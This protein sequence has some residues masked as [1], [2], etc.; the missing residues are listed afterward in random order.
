M[1]CIT[2]KSLD[3]CEGTVGEGSERKKVELEKILREYTNNHEQNVCIGMD[4]GQQKGF[5]S[6]LTGCSKDHKFL[7]GQV[8]VGGHDP[9]LIK[10]LSVT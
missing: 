8:M 6:N 7:T 9:G 4:N 2:R 1:R 10:G 5:Y 3:F